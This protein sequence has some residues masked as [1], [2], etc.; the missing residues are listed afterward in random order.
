MTIIILSAILIIITC[1]LLLVS[2]VFIKYWRFNPPITSSRRGE[3]YS[4]SIG[5][6]AH[7]DF[8][9][10]NQA[11][12]KDKS[13]NNNHGS[14]KKI[15]YYHYPEKIISTLFFTKIPFKTAKMVEGLN[16]N[17]IHINSKQWV[18]GGNIKAYNT[19]TFTIALW[20]WK[21]DSKH[22]TPTIMAKSSWP[23]DGWWLCTKPNTR[24]IDMGIA[25]GSSN[26]HIES[27]YELPINEWHHIAV[28]MDNVAHKIQFFIDGLSFGKPHENVPAWLI[29]WNHDLFLGDYD[30][31][32]R[33][34]WYGK[35][36]DARYFDR[37]LSSEEI[38]K[39]HQT[40]NPG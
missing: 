18:S 4:E 28:T 6:V 26:K 36:S 39:I 5:L 21:D 29:N 13:G 40:N 23:Y 16:G 11:I 20:I 34:H 30:G 12:I 37:I 14:L 33:W 9:G 17:T 7:W 32:G 38:F 25:W 3:D 15:V 2:F 31:S 35:L 22:R 19:N 10:I 1:I 8:E 24:F 27:G